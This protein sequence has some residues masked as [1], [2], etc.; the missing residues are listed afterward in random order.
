MVGLA[1]FVFVT[2]VGSQGKTRDGG[3]AFEA[4]D[5]GVAAKIA[6]EGYFVDHGFKFLT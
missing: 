5:F 1:V 4:P 6:D 3:A 2:F